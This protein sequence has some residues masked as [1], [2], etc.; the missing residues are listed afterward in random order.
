MGGG[1]VIMLGGPFFIESNVAPARAK[2]N[3]SNGLLLINA[4]TYF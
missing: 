3:E 4:L 1:G 2:W